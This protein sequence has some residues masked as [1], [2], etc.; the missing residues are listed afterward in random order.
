M[1]DSVSKLTLIEKGCN[2][3]GEE[4]NSGATKGAGS[5]RG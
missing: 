4:F 1:N 5:L 3:D 2:Y